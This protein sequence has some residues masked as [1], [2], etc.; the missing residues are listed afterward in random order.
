M[1]KSRATIVV[2]GKNQACAVYGAVPG[3][4][5]VTFRNV[6]VDGNRQNLGIIYGGIALLEFGGNT[7]NQ[8]VLNVRAFE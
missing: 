2:Q 1:G 4:N 7:V 3:A 8:R 6:Q 5:N